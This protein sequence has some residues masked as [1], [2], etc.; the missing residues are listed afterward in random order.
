MAFRP[1]VPNLPTL[2][3]DILSWMVVRGKSGLT[4]TPGTF[5]AGTCSS[6]PNNG[7]N[8]MTCHAFQAIEESQLDRLI[9]FTFDKTLPCQRAQ[10]PRSRCLS[11]PA[12]SVKVFVVV[13]VPRIVRDLMVQAMWRAP[14]PIDVIPSLDPGPESQMHQGVGALDAPKT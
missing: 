8:L 10:T 7:L 3:C 14:R 13:A 6:G 5:P 1:Y 12:H 11:T 2:C 9:F 4:A